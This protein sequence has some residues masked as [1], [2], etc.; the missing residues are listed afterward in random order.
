[1]TPVQAWQLLLDRVQGKA[2]KGARR[3]S[4]WRNVRADYL[5]EHPACELCGDERR[6]VEVHHVIPFHVAPDLE[7]DHENLISLCNGARGCH[8]LFGHLRN[9]QSTNLS[10][11]EDAMVWRGRFSA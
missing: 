6:R 1:M 10:V 3:S 2:P 11:R 4:A 9:Y 7:L 5:A 8:L